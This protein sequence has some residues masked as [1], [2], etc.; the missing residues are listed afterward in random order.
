M[1]RLVISENGV[2]ELT[3]VASRKTGEIE[4][5][6]QLNDSIESLE[7]GMI[8]FVDAKENEVVLTKTADCVDALYLHFSNPRR[9]EDGR[10]GMKHFKYERSEDYLPRLYKL[11]PG[12]IFRTNVMDAANFNYVG[13]AT[14]VDGV[15]TAA[16]SG[17]FMVK[18]STM[19]DDSQ[20]FEVRFLGLVSSESV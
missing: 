11:T 8:V 4:A 13:H 16:D 12:D 3:K 7:N 17:E 15:L 9:Y 19:P 6:A 5:Q 2:A 1:A 18:P 10:T 14:V 20:G